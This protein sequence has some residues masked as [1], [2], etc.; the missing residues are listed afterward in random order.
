VQPA[1]ATAFDS[2]SSNGGAYSSNGGAYVF[3]GN[4]FVQA[5]GYF[6]CVDFE[7]QFQSSQK[8][9]NILEDIPQVKW[10]F[11]I[12]TSFGALQNESIPFP[13]VSN[14]VADVASTSNYPI[15]I[16]VVQRWTSTGASVWTRRY[17]WLQS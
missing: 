2:N 7:D 1:W 14:S 6:F 16:S 15:N 10:L 9:F 17:R 12:S 4:K 5:N 11:D 3:Y 8:D 13:Q